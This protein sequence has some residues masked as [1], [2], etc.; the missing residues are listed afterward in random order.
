MKKKESKVT[1][2]KNG[3]S[4]Y[5]DGRLLYSKGIRAK[6]SSECIPVQLYGLKECETCLLKDDKT[7]DKK[8]NT[9]KCSCGGYKIRI[10]G[11]NK[12]GFKVPLKDKFYSI[13]DN[14]NEN[15]FS[16]WALKK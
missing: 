14:Y 2:F 13:G 12:R 1:L 7:F 15:D 10:N 16:K 9:W 5:A 11:K 3:R 6:L 4:K 8:S